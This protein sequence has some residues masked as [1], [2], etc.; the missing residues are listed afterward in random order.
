MAAYITHKLMVPPR[1]PVVVL[2]PLLCTS[3]YVTWFSRPAFTGP[4]QMTGCLQWPQLSGHRFTL[5][6]SEMRMK[7][8]I[9]LF[10][11]W[12]PK[13]RCC[14]RGKGKMFL[15]NT[16][17]LW[18]LKVSPQKLQTFLVFG[19]FFLVTLGRFCLLQWFGTGP[20]VPAATKLSVGA[21]WSFA[22]KK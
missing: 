6:R 11:T 22:I 3:V 12:S 5:Q 18:F 20:S 7:Q 15:S 2:A 21:S 4:S 1:T 14:W 13:W 19:P 9:C 16:L 8:M 10:F 17:S